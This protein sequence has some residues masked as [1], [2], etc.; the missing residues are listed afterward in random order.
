MDEVGATIATQA[1]A[2]STTSSAPGT[3]TAPTPSELAASGQNI[4]PSYLFITSD[5]NDDSHGIPQIHSEDE[6]SPDHPPVPKITLKR[7]KKAK[8]AKGEG[9]DKSAAKVPKIKKRKKT[10]A[11]KSS[12]KAEW[13]IVKLPLSQPFSQ[14]LQTLAAKQSEQSTTSKTSRKADDSGSDKD[15][16]DSTRPSSSKNKTA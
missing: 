13:L 12:G 11:T 4:P 6:V 3:S 9:E 7:K 10:D 2:T 8:K 15:D 16:D 1:V 5:S 14:Q